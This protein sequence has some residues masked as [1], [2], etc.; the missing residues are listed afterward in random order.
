MKK[1]LLLFIF[2]L[3]LL[4]KAQLFTANTVTVL[5]TNPDSCTNVNI[6]VTAYMGCIN[7]TVGP[8]SFQVTG[9]T[10]DL[11]VS[12]RSSPICAGA[13]SYPVTSFGI[14]GLAPGNYNIS[15]S[16]FLDGVLINTISGGT[17]NVATCNVTAL[18]E[19]NL[20]QI[21][22]YPNPASEK[23]FVDQL[24][25]EEE[26]MQVQ[27]FDITGKEQSVSLNYTKGRLEI[28]IIDLNSGIYFLQLR[29]GDEKVI[30]K[31]LVQ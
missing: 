30:K 6:D 28:D 27:L 21:E 23:I 24:S 25:S 14:S 3:P 15:A 19:Y 9:N 7:F 16:A 11:S 18:A 8:G 20:A 13:I 12:C 31:I 4:L 10:I 1:A 5:T 2:C 26:Q 29:Q 17:L 22:V